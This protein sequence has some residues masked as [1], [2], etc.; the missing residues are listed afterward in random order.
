[1]S[2]A[3]MAMWT[4]WS[5]HTCYVTDSV[6]RNE[7]QAIMM[8]PH[9]PTEHT[10]CTHVYCVSQVPVL[11]GHMRNA[12]KTNVSHGFKVFSLHARIEKCSSNY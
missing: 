11:K 2:A 8:G 3:E 10:P 5:P 12:C 1:M 6:F 4:F 7:I 9:V